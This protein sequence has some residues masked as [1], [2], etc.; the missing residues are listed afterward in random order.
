[1]HAHARKI[2]P[3]PATVTPSHAAPGIPGSDGVR[4]KSGT[5]ELVVFIAN[6]KPRTGTAEASET[7]QVL[8]LSELPVQKDRAFAPKRSSDSIAYSNSITKPAMP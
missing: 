3:I 5:H 6:T 1:V 4:K 2:R 8:F 7:A